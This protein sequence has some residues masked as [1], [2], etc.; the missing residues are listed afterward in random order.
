MSEDGDEERWLPT[1]EACISATGSMLMSAIGNPLL[2]E[3][4]PPNELA[5]FVLEC[6]APPLFAVGMWD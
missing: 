3:D 6:A 2:L 4:S 5:D 1:R